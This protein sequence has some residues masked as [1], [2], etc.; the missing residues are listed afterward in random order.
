MRHLALAICL[1]ACGNAA[2]LPDAP[3]DT[4]PACGCNYAGAITVG[5]VTPVGADQLSGLAISLS[6]PDTVWTQNDG[7]GDAELFT[8]S[9]YGAGKGIAVL[10]AVAAIDWEDI[11]SGPCGSGTCIYVADTGDNQL[12]RASVRI[13]EVDDPGEFRGRIEANYRAF[14]LVYPDGPHDVE[15]LFVDPRDQATYV[16]TKQLTAATVFRMPRVEGITSTAV[17]VSTFLP[18]A[19]DAR[20]TAADLRVDECGVRLLIRTYSSMWELRANAE[21]S[22][23]DL[24]STAPVSVPVAVEPQGEAVAYLGSGHSY[25]TVNDGVAPELSRVS[26]E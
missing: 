7:A 8:L 20:I 1:G 18:P 26:C 25:I 9:T 24:F 23:E 17:P 5:A 4:T 2:E 13:Y 11:A 21:A 19:N 10:P 14:D 12:D 6:S 16:I 22:I 15:A 3:L